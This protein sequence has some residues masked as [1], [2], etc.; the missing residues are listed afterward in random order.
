[1]LHAADDH[2]TRRHPRVWSFGARSLSSSA[3]TTARTD[4]EPHGELAWFRRE[5]G[6]ALWR[7]RTFARSLAR[8]HYG[9]AGVLVALMAGFALSLSVD[10][11]TRGL[12]EGRPLLLRPV[13]YTHLT[14]PT[15]R[16]V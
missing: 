14:L 7:P 15:K 4:D 10:D 9:V 2:S 16:I 11:R 5:V 12:Y 13:S 1:M 6:W 8:E 3:M